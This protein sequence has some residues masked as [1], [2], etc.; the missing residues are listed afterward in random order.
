MI[1]Q[2][3][4]IRDPRMFKF[5]SRKEAAAYLT[6]YNSLKKKFTA[7]FLAQLA[8]QEKGPDFSREGTKTVVYSEYDL[9]KWLHLIQTSLRTMI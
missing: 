9:D 1:A 2:T 3:K 8:Y 4:P 7:N 6:K 5:Y